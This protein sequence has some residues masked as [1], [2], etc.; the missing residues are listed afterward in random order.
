MK[1]AGRVL[2]AAFFCLVTGISSPL[3]AATWEDIVGT[4]SATYHPSLKVS[5]YFTDKS[6]SYGDVSF[7]NSF[8]LLAYEN[9]N[10]KVRYYH[11][12]FLIENGKKIIAELNRN[13]FLAVI[14][15][16]IQENASRAGYTV[17]DLSYDISIFKVSKCKINERNMSLGKVKVTLKG[18]VSAYVD[19]VY[20]TKKLSY[21]SVITFG[22][23][24]SGDPPTWVD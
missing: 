7:Y 22:P 24:I 23:K 17:T 12:A 11:G 19:G 14:T 9:D 20:K 3:H 4:W 1:R 5:G 15:E 6:V 21:K 13:E 10:G 2:L 16:W 8:D 18:T